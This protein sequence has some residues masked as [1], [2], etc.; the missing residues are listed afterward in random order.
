MRVSG[1][2]QDRLQ[3]ASR[4]CLARLGEPLNRRDIFHLAQQCREVGLEA[5]C[6]D[7]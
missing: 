5:C 6:A 4:P 3:Y 2:L 1:V 7:S